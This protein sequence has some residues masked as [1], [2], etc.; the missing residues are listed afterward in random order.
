M[1]SICEIIY[2][3]VGVV[4]HQA[5]GYGRELT[6]VGDKDRHRGVM[7]SEKARHGIRMGGWTRVPL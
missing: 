7:A 1:A 5:S 2:Y 6:L 4:G 3:R